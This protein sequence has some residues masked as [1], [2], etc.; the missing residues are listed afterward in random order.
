MDTVNGFG[1]VDGSYTYFKAGSGFTM[2]LDST[3]MKHNLPAT[4]SFFD[5][6]IA[7]FPTPSSL[8][9]QD[10]IVTRNGVFDPTDATL[11]PNIGHTELSSSWV[12]NVGSDN[13]HVGGCVNATTEIVTTITGHRSLCRLKWGTMLRRFTAF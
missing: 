4:P 12:N 5:F 2:G 7:N 8:Q 10:T 1:M 3:N 11:T 9:I 13:T 6:S